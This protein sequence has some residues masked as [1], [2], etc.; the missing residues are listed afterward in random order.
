[1]EGRLYDRI[2]PLD[3]LEV[4][5]GPGFLEEEWIKSVRTPIGEASPSRK[6]GI[7]FLRLP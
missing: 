4:V 7:M 1:M 6:W 5:T 3:T 2:E